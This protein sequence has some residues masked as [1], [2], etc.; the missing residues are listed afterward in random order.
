MGE[1][2]IEPLEL[3]SQEIAECDG[4]AARMLT[5]VFDYVDQARA[6]R[7]ARAHIF[8]PE[9]MPPDPMPLMYQAGYEIEQRAGAMHVTRGYACANPVTPTIEEAGGPE[10]P[11]VRGPNLDIALLHAVRS[12]DWIDDSK[13]VIAGGSAAGHMSLMLAAET[14]PVAAVVVD[15]APVNLPYNMAYFTMVR[16]LNDP[17]ILAT[18]A[19]QIAHDAIQLLGE[20]PLAP[21]FAEHAVISHLQRITCPVSGSHSSADMLV[22]A[23]QL[24]RRFETEFDRGLFPQGYERVPERLTSD[25]RAHTRLDDLLPPDSLEFVVQPPPPADRV[26]IDLVWDGARVA[27]LE[28]PVG[29]KQWTVLVIDEGPPEPDLGHLK[30]AVVVSRHAFLEKWVCGAIPAGQL[31]R[32]KLRT[33]MMRAGGI[34]WI[35][36]S[37]PHLDRP[38]QERKDVIRGLKLFIAYSAENRSA[39]ESLVQ[40]ITG[41]LRAVAEGVGEECI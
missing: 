18:N 21:E 7:R 8:V 26:V 38:D 19:T 35:S 5:V 4:E 3:I 17:K 22:P 23:E 34:E 25:V 41:D 16:R 30:H 10:N 33:L 13:V 29:S 6:P 15:C 27:E 2:M 36:A 11:L 28:A 39:F 20:D 32:E 37:I 24:S 12:L 31:T 9:Q 40:G 1:L 14:F